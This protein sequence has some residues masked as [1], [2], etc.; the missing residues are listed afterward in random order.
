MYEF[1]VVLAVD[2]DGGQLR[3][4]AHANNLFDAINEA[5]TFAKDKYGDDIE[6]VQAFFVR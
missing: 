2:N 1:L 3:Y 6:L 5:K 4:W